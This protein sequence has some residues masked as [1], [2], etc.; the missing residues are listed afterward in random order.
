MQ[1]V[2]GTEDSG[3]LQRTLRLLSWIALPISV[4]SLLETFGDLNDMRQWLQ[5]IVHAYRHFTSVLVPLFEFLKLPAGPAAD[6]VVSLSII[7]ISLFARASPIYDQIDLR[8]PMEL[9]QFAAYVVWSAFFVLPT[10][11]IF[12]AIFLALQGIPLTGDVMS[13]AFTRVIWT[14]YALMA[15]LLLPV[16]AAWCLVSSVYLVVVYAGSRATGETPPEE[17]T[18]FVISLGLQILVVSTIWIV[19]L[20]VGTN[21][22][23]AF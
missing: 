4:I 11:Y 12:V 8:P 21:L 3:R 10:S 13:D 14:V 5:N 20:V 23:F 9:D 19:A 7:T 6:S 22:V 2:Q 17:L 15:M 16:I 1:D 18:S